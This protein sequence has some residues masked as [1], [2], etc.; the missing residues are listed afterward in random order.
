MNDD[1]QVPEVMLPWLLG[2]LTFQYRS[3]S[4]DGMITWASTRTRDG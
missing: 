3:G 1:G 4:E 2:G